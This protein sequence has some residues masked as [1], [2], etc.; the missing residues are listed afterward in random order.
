MHHVSCVARVAST[1]GTRERVADE[2]SCAHPRMLP[3]DQL[4]LKAGCWPGERIWMLSGMEWIKSP[5]RN[6]WTW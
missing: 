4:G 3:A 6:S 1:R 5:S 2:A